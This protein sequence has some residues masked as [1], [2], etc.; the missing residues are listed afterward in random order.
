M[1][2]R[3]MLHASSIAF[4]HPFTDKKLKFTADTPSDMA[5]LIKLLKNE[6]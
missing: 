6:I 1:A 3:Q 4:V 5:N 2:K